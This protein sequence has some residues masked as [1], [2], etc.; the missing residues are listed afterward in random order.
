MEQILFSGLPGWQII[1]ILIAMTIGS[2]MVLYLCYLLLKG[3]L[4]L[5]TM[6]EEGRL[7]EDKHKLWKALKVI[8]KL[9]MLFLTVVA[10]VALFSGGFD[11]LFLG[12]MVALI[13]TGM[14]C[15]LYRKQS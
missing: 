2:V 9:W 5:F 3:I 11:T 12:I 10:W 6:N 7:E 1:L 8:L 15:L 4:I 13:V 14:T